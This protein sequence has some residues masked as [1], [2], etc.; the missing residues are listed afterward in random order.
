MT[1]EVSGC[2]SPRFVPLFSNDS[3]TQ[4][5]RRMADF[6]DE[7]TVADTLLPLIRDAHPVSLRVLDWLTVNKAKSQLIMCPKADGQMCNIHGSYKST[8]SV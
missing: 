4:L 8:L 6:Y 7:S 2:E 1:E 3:K 5:E